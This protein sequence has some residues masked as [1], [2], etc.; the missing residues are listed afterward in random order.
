MYIFSSFCDVNAFVTHA[1]TY[2]E[3][4]YKALSCSTSVACSLQL[5]CITSH[6]GYFVIGKLSR[7]L[8]FHGIHQAGVWFHAFL[9]QMVGLRASGDCDLGNIWMTNLILGH[10]K[11]ASLLL[12]II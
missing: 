9:R 7:H 6:I 10:S 12:H 3:A 4:M 5:R 8:A 1:H 11:H 2:M